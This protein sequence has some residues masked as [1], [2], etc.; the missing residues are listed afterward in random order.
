[1]VLHLFRVDASTQAYL[2]LVS[3][4]TSADTKPG[5]G[6]VSNAIAQGWEHNKLFGRLIHGKSDQMVLIHVE[7]EVSS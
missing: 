3:V 7:L 4:S 6:A 2:M 1:M 5:F